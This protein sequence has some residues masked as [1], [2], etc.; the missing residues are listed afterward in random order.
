L[1]MPEKILFSRQGQINPNHLL[2]E[3]GNRKPKI[4]L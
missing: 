4:A 1:S 3:T 2:R